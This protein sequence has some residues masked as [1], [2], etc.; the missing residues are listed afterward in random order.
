M[1]HLFACVSAF[2]A[3]AA[4]GFFTAEPLCGSFGVGAVL[5]A[6]GDAVSVFTASFV[7]CVCA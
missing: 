4:S 1:R 3:L 6:V 5:V 7:G 2:G